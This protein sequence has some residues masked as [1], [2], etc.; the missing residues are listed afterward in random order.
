[1]VFRLGGHLIVGAD[2]DDVARGDSL[3]VDLVVGRHHA[4]SL[5]DAQV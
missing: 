5:L 1:L 4:E 2:R 3:E